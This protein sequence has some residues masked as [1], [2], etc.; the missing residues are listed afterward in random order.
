MLRGGKI[1]ADGAH[2]G[3]G[4]RLAGV[5]VDALPKGRPQACGLTRRAG[6]TL[7]GMAVGAYQAAG[8]IEALVASAGDNHLRLACHCSTAEAWWGGIAGTCEIEKTKL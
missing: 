8:R 6:R 4:L 7:K 1:A 3:A 5:R 2:F